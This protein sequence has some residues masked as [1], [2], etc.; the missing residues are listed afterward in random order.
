[1]RLERLGLAGAGRPFN[2]DVQGLG[3]RSG[4]R[5]VAEG[6]EGF[7]R[8]PGLRSSFDVRRQ[9]AAGDASPRG[10]V[11]SEEACQGRQQT[12]EQD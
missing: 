11:G 9:P 10:G 6:D 3:L 2:Q 1:M 5:D 8:P 12:T 4:R 7:A